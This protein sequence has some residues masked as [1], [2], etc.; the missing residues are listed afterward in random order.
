MKII[1][2]PIRLPYMSETVKRSMLLE[3][4]RSL[5]RHNNYDTDDSGYMHLLLP[6][7]LKLIENI[8]DIKRLYNT[9]DARVYMIGKEANMTDLTIISLLEEKEHELY[10]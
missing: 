4:I 5:R 6:Y 3:C 2:L 10:D 9:L 8:R 7:C 1:Q